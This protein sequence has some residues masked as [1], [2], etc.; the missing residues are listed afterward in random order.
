VS[1]FDAQMALAG[2][3]GR[4][5]SIHCVK[6]HGHLYEWLRGQ[7][8]EALPPTLALHSYTGSPDMARALLT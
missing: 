4:P 5:V 8:V 6:A 3:L 2:E 1:A 7:P